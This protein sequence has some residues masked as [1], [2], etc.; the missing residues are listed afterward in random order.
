MNPGEYPSPLT[1]IS[2]I[3]FPAVAG[4]TT[5]RW[6]NLQVGHQAAVLAASTLVLRNS[7]DQSTTLQLKASNTIASGL[8]NVGS[9]VTI[10]PGGFTIID[11]SS[12]K[13]ILEVYCSD[14]TTTVDGQL[15]SATTWEIMPLYRSPSYPAVLLGG[16]S[17]GPSSG[18]TEVIQ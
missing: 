10:V 15:K 6:R 9:A 13:P 7:G 16:K 11:F 1:R 12:T 3:S 2:P 18:F 8:T 17:A 14:G 5:V 4:Y